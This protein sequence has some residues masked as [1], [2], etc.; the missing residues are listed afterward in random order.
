MVMYFSFIRYAI[1]SNDL[2][3]DVSAINWKD[4]LVFCQKQSITGVVF[5]GVK[6]YEAQ[7]KL[8]IP[9]EILFEWVGLAEQIKYRN[10]LTNRRCVELTEIFREAGFES[11]I[12]KGQGN[13]LLYPN[14]LS[15]TPGD[16]DI[17]VNGERGQVIDFVKERTTNVFEQ[18]H[19]IDFPI[20]QDVPVEVHFTPANLTHPRYKKLFQKYAESVFDTENHHK[21]LLPNESIQVSV[22]TLDFNIVY[23]MAH[24][25]THFFDE[26]VGLRHLI[27]YYFVLKNLRLDSEEVQKRFKQFGLLKFAKG[28]MW[29]EK[30]LLGLDDK[31]LVVEPSEKIGRVII[32]E[33]LE[34]GNFGKHDTRYVLRNY[35]LLGRAVSD[36]YRLLTLFT[37]FPSEV[38][39]KLIW[40][41][42]NQKW[43]IKKW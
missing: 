19:H 43:K 16:I 21:V 7:E 34:G 42:K 29:I 5:D 22:S 2:V 4:F 32:H 8:C 38:V 11:C 37:I 9:K 6:R 12:L 26:G 24:M 27:D 31:F 23:Q 18:Y 25:M 10:I 36:G 15:R 20:F 41:I 14:T 39:W 28:V 30:C 13:A 40:K 3:P 35:G 17:W 33:V 1:G